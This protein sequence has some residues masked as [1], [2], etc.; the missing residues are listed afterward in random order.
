MLNVLMKL[1]VVIVVIVV[2]VVTVG[3]VKLLL[4]MITHTLWLRLKALKF[5][6]QLLFQLNK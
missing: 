3:T 1:K 6:V 2:T 4:K 5:I